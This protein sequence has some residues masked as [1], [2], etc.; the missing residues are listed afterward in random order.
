[1]EEQNS[2]HNTRRLQLAR[3][4]IDLHVIYLTRNADDWLGVQQ[5]CIFTDLQ[6][7]ASS[8]EAAFSHSYTFSLSHFLSRS[9]FL[10]NSMQLFWWRGTT[11]G[12]AIVFFK[13]NLFELVGF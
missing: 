10:K 12:I 2:L 9:F 6:Y 7:R 13:V 11:R 5:N 3:S 4:E 1:M 8:S